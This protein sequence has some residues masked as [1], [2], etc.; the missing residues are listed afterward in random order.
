MKLFIRLFTYDIVSVAI[1]L[2]ISR[3][4]ILPFDAFSILVGL[5]FSYI[6]TI[7]KLT[8]IDYGKDRYT[9]ASER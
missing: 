6:Y 3:Y 4:G 5:L 8:I 1:C 2:V 9:N 7:N